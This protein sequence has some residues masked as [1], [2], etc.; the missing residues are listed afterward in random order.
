M[1]QPFTLPRFL[2]TEWVQSIQYTY[3]NTKIIAY[4]LENLKSA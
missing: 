1:T 4:Y 2:D 3:E